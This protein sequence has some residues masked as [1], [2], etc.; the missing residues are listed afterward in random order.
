[1]LSIRRS[2]S[3][4]DLFLDD[5]ALDAPCRDSACLSHED[6]HRGQDGLLEY[7]RVAVDLVLGETVLQH[8]DDSSVVLAHAVARRESET[9]ALIVRVVAFDQFVPRVIQHGFVAHA[10]AVP[11]VRDLVVST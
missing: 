3:P 11:L 4:S 2:S 8:R 10:A 6:L 5:F 1:M 7:A 9:A